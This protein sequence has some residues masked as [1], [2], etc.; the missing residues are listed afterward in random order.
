MDYP[1]NAIIRM[2]QLGDSRVLDAQ[3]VWFCSTCFVCS[4]RC[5][6]G[7]KVAETMDA[8]RIIV[9]RKEQSMLTP[10]NLSSENL[11]GLPPIALVSTFR[12]YTG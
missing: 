11:E 9:A 7:V 5:P 6:K 10:D 3:S 8:V 4:V 2:I 12:K 1:P